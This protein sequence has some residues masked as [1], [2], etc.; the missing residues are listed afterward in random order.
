MLGKLSRFGGG[1]ER[2]LPL[3][4]H[5]CLD[6]RIRLG[7]RV[8]SKG[9][10]GRDCHRSYNATNL[11]DF[12]LFP[13]VSRRWTSK[14]FARGDIR[15]V[16]FS[17]HSY[18]SSA[19]LGDL[20]E[21]QRACECELRSSYVARRR[22]F[23]IRMSSNAHARRLRDQVGS[24]PFVTEK[25]RHTVALWSRNGIDVTTNYAVLLPA[26]QK[27]GELVHRTT[28]FA[29]CGRQA[30]ARVSSSCRTPSTRKP[31]YSTCRPLAL[32]GQN[33]LIFEG[34]LAHRSPDEEQ[35]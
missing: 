25:G 11:Q 3:R 15:A 7:A 6:R 22:G 35:R 16:L 21:G 1:H 4:T 13:T 33:G 31:S 28:N 27:I 18:A 5:F 10:C 8:L 24:I 23:Q 29:G 30:G 19:T 9:K 12:H 2:P 26:L 32:V 20:H 34:L 17:L 14:T